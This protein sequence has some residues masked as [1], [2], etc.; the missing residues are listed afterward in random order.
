[1]ANEN[2]CVF[3]FCNIFF[4]LQH[5]GQPITVVARALGA[6]W[7]GLSDEA[8]QPYRAK[9]AVERERVERDVEKWKAAGGVVPAPT[10]G[11]TGGG[12]PPPGVSLS[13]VDMP[14]ARV[15]KIC[16]LDPEVKNL[17][18]EGLVMVTKAAEF[19]LT[20]LATECVKTAQIQNRRKLL[21]DD[22]AQVCSVREQFLFLREDI[23]DL[24]RHLQNENA[25]SARQTKAAAAKKGG[26]DGN[27]TQGKPITDFFKSAQPASSSSS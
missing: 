21:P 27:T 25:E 10:A 15:K 13:S 22:I 7:S 3:P 11:S 20:H 14:I 19:F 24:H 8:K 23:K 5:P 6:L 18:K 4:F 2:H 12:K 16:K 26:G 9:A 17:T 1:V